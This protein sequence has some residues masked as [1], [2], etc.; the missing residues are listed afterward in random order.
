MMLTRQTIDGLREFASEG[1]GHYFLT[2]TEARDILE[3][4]EGHEQAIR[5]A[6]EAEREDHRQD[7]EIYACHLV[8]CLSNERHR[9]RHRE[10]CA[11]CTCGFTDAAIRARGETEKT[12]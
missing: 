4:V 10:P 8:G 5:A 11:D 9:G 2:P 12:A 1:G 3:L 7:F 6:V